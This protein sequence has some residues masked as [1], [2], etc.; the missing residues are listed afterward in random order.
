MDNVHWTSSLEASCD[1]K[2]RSGV[3]WKKWW[4]RLVVG[5]LVSGEQSVLRP[6]THVT[7]A[8]LF[9]GE[10][11]AFPAIWLDNCQ[12]KSVGTRKTNKLQMW[13]EVQS[14]KEHRLAK[15]ISTKWYKTI[16]VSWGQIKLF[17]RQVQDLWL[18]MPFLRDS[19]ALPFL[20]K[21]PSQV[22]CWNLKWLGLSTFL[23]WN[24][25]LT[26]SH[27]I[28]R[29][30]TWETCNRHFGHLLTRASVLLQKGL[31]SLLLNRIPSHPA[32]AIGG[33]PQIIDQDC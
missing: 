23:N 28:L 6:H 22:I 2:K 26:K 8:W 14:G 15:V 1:A 29:V 12:D 30:W 7:Q 21:S 32:P 3:K 31:S 27:L 9:I 17:K 16:S 25:L 33:V 24:W 13:S 11:T 10:A 20:F 4:G 18:K 19:L 5:A